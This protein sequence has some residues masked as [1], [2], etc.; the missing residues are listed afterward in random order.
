[1]E[2]LNVTMCLK[3]LVVLTVLYVVSM[4]D[5]VSSVAGFHCVSNSLVVYSTRLFT[6]VVD[7]CR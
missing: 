2:T 3:K 5:L 1:M 7:F 4:V 6:Y